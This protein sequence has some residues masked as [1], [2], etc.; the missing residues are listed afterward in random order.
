MVRVPIHLYLKNSHVPVLIQ[1][2]DLPLGTRHCLHKVY[3]KEGKLIQHRFFLIGT[4]YESDASFLA[5]ARCGHS[6]RNKT[7]KRT[8]DAR[9]HAPVRDQG[10]DPPVP[11]DKKAEQGVMHS[12]TSDRLRFK[13]ATKDHR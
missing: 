1:I 6:Y 13:K 9:K 11:C 3:S 12:C 10:P 8:T 4:G 2:P 7:M 5:N